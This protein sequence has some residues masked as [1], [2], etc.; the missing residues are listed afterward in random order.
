M[1]KKTLREMLSQRAFRSELSCYSISIL[2]SSLFQLRLISSFLH[3]EILL[4]LNYLVILLN[5]SCE[6]PFHHVIRKADCIYSLDQ[7]CWG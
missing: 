7:G 4:Q 1:N 5:E 6:Y 2:R 3:L